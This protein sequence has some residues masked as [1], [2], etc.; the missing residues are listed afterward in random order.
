MK[1]TFAF[2]TYIDAKS[3][4]RRPE[5]AKFCSGNQNLLTRVPTGD[6]NPQ[7]VD[8]YQCVNYRILE[9]FYKFGSFRKL[10]ENKPAF[11]E[12]QTLF[13]SILENFY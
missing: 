9:K 8:N 10:F 4:A 3:P 1:P 12:K 11:R 2:E 5:G 7:P 6:H 13:R